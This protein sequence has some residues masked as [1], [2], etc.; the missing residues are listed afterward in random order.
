MGTTQDENCLDDESFKVILFTFNS[1]P[2]GL[3]NSLKTNH[4]E[5]EYNQMEY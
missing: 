1:L 5:Y 4:L 3:R 2:N